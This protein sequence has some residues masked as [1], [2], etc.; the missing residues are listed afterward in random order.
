VTSRQLTNLKL[1]ILNTS[2]ERKR[3]F[4]FYCDLCDSG[5]MKNNA[6]NRHLETPEEGSTI[7]CNFVIVIF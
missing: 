7:N 5:F 6:L 2:E 1:H 3:E 4:L